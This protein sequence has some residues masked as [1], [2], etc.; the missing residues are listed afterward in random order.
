MYKIVLQFGLLV[1]FFSV[2]YFSQREISLEKVLFYSFLTFIITMT[3][4][5]GIAIG[6]TKKQ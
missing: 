5:S 2:I 1:F 3:I 6:L 4:L